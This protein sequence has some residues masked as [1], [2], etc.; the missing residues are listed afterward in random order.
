MNMQ[1]SARRIWKGVACGLVLAAAATAFGADVEGVIVKKDSG[2]LAGAIRYLASSK[3]YLVTSRGARDV[4]LRVP[5]DQVARVEVPPPPGLGEA[6]RAVRG[7]QYGAAV[8]V[9]EN[10]MKDYRMMQHDVT[11]AGYLAF[12]YM[13]M[14][15]PE[16]ALEMCRRVIEGNPD[17]AVSAEMAPIYWQAL[18]KAG[19]DATLRKALDDAAARGDRATAAR[20]QLMR[21]DLEAKNGRHKEAL[22]DG[23]L[24]TA[25]LFR[26]VK[27]V[28]PEALFKAAQSFDQLEQH[29][30]AERMRKE[31]L[32]KYPNDEYSRRL[33]SGTPGG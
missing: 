31:L 30:Y 33:A 14:N 10:I 16:K 5:L 23:Y 12:A 24:R 28:Q 1:A 11:A 25:L 6:A 9:L 29:P 26:D 17:A 21:G 2:R 4:T 22:V 13:G 27:E 18:L 3:E 15:Q 19:Q 8:P 7:G 20:A 32:A